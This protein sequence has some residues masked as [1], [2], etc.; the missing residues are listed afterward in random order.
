MTDKPD[1]WPENPYPADL[2]PMTVEEYV[3]AIPD[4][5][6]RTAISG[7]IGRWAWDVASDAIWEKWD[8]KDISENDVWW[9]LRELKSLVDDVDDFVWAEWRLE[10]IREISDKLT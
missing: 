6:L 4:K 3:A 7:C 10:K 1:W 8:G 2:F 9:L 5:K